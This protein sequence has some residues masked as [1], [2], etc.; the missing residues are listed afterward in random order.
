ML[1][2]II[3]CNG[4]YQPV[5]GLSGFQLIAAIEVHMCLR[6]DGPTVHVRGSAVV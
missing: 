2:L 5:G 6:D 3:L 1:Y 4:P